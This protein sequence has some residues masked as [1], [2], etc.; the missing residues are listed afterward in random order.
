MR[1]VRDLARRRKEFVEV[2]LPAR[3]VC[4]CTVAPRC[5]PVEDEFYPVAKARG[6]FGLAAPDRL[7]DGH[8]V[9]ESNVLDQH[10]PDDR[11][12]VRL[13]SVAP[14]LAMLRVLPASFVRLDVLFCRTAVNESAA[15]CEAIR[16]LRLALMSAIG[17]VPCASFARAA[18]AASLA[19]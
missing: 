2:P 3:R 18:R 7:Q 5:C 1:L 4:P 8:D 6:G 13:D 15:A 19:C 16:A 10:L 11:S 14:L 9:R 17:S 12:G